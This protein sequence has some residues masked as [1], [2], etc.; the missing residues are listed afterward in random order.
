MYSIRA[1]VTGKCLYE[2]LQ[3]AANSPFF[4]LCPPLHLQVDNTDNLF[5]APA[6]VAGPVVRRVTL[7][8]VLESAVLTSGLCTEVL[9]GSVPSLLAVDPPG[10]TLCYEF[11][12]HQFC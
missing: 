9:P 4:L 8:L 3:T 6:G 12:C 11:C 7:A 2:E 5:H 10:S 1:V